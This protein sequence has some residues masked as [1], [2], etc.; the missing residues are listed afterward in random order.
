MAPRRSLHEPGQRGTTAFLVAGL[1]VP[2]DYWCGWA[3]AATGDSALEPASSIGRISCSSWA[4]RAFT[5]GWSGVENHC[6]TP[7]QIAAL[8]EAATSSGDMDDGCF[9][10]CNPSISRR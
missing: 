7:A 6:F 2:A 10:R 5:G 1:D 4:T 3:A 9:S 8:A